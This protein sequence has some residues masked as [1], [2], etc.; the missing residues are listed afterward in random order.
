LAPAP[1]RYVLNGLLRQ[2]F[3][4][5]HAFIAPACVAALR[6]WGEHLTI[7]GAKPIGRS[8]VTWWLHNYAFYVALL[9]GIVAILAP[10]L[11]IGWRR[12]ANLVSV[13]LFLGVVPPLIDVQLFGVGGFAYRYQRGLGDL[14]WLLYAPPSY[15]PPGESSVLWLS[16]ALVACI[17]LWYGRTGPLRLAPGLLMYALVFWFLAIVPT[18]A[19]TLQLANANASFLEW[20]TA[21]LVL[22]AMLGH[23]VGAGLGR[24][25]LERLPQIMLAPL[26]CM[27]GGAFAQLEPAP[28]GYAT[29]LLGLISVGFALSNDLFDRVGDRAQGRQHAISSTSAAILT[30][31]PWLAIGMALATRIDLGL[32][33]MAFAAVAFAYH[34]PPFRLKRLM[35]LSY[36]SEG[37]LAGLAIAAGMSCIPGRLPT[38]VEW[39]VLAIATL[40]MPLVL[41]FKDDKDQQ[42]DAVARNATLFVVGAR[43]GLTAKQ[44][45]LAAATALGLGLFVA[46]G[47]AHTRGVHQAE[48]A[49]LGAGALLAPTLFVW[50]QNRTWAFMTTLLTCEAFLTALAY[51]FAGRP[52]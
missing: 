4:V 6:V 32:C 11:R 10:C 48:L 38:S 49:T 31:L 25:T 18:L 16:V 46:T 26:F 36:L 44:L 1:I 33:L 24:R 45:R 34:S 40:G 21:L 43:H 13:G 17:G 29:L 42:G 27:V 19:D 51:A 30:G 14:P 5:G 35:L 8:P 3:A 41:L 20:L 37:W 22:C 39:R 47:F 23:I 28:V 52:G 15:L 2:P 50:M 12:I 7:I 9:W